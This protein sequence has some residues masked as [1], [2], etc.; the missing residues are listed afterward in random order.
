M[1]RAKAGQAM[2]SASMGQ[3]W[4]GLTPMTCGAT[5]GLTP[6]THTTIPLCRPSFC[7]PFSDPLHRCFLTPSSPQLEHRLHTDKQPSH[8][9]GSPASQSMAFTGHSM[10]LKVI[11]FL[12]N[13]ALLLD[14]SHL[15]Q[16]ICPI[17]RW[18]LQAASVPGTKGGSGQAHLDEHMKGPVP[19][20]S[21]RPPSKNCW[22]Q[23]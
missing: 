1:A 13:L 16:H 5:E 7:S 4:E 18:V 23:L 17:P 14:P 20:S 22:L 3:P 8:T 21:S 2:M 11:S 9:S 6:H 19:Q 10:I 12:T 15:E